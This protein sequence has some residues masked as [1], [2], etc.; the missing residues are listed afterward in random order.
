MLIGPK[1]TLSDGSRDKK[2]RGSLVAKKIALCKRLVP[3]LV[4][5]LL[6]ARRYEEQG[7]QRKEIRS[8]SCGSPLDLLSAQLRTFP[9]TSRSLEIVWSS[10]GQI[11]DPRLRCTER[12]GFDWSTRSDRH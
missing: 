7:N 2:S 10:G 11:L 4:C 5:H 12:S 3:R 9:G 8:D 1:L 6:V